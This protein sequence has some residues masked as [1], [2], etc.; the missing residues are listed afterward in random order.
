MRRGFT[1]MELS[2]VVV[3]ITAV[4]GISSGV[5]VT[6]RR[7]ERLTRAYTEAPFVRLRGHVL[8]D[9]KDVVYTNFCDIGW[10]VHEDGRLVVVACLD[11]L[12]KGAAGQA[13]QIFNLAF[14]LDER[15]GLS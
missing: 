12:V 15:D 10:S 14:G 6:L 4:A 1:L 3:L 8:P 9:I 13:V 5:V 11:N 7:S 2:I